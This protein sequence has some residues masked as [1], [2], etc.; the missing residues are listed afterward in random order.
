[1]LIFGIISEPS[2]GGGAAP[3]APFLLLVAG[4]A[5]AEFGR[6]GC[7]YLAYASS[8]LLICLWTFSRD[9]V[10]GHSKKRRSSTLRS[11][12]KLSRDSL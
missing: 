7:A 1:M 5:A 8:E 9:S 11:A 2:A 6:I 10:G 3:S 4:W 12:R